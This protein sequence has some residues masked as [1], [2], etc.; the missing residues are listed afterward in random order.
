MAPAAAA[1]LDVSAAAELQIQL[2]TLQERLDKVE[3]ARVKECH[4]AAVEHGDQL[5][6]LHHKL[7]AAEMQAR[8]PCL[9]ALTPPKNTN[10][11]SGA[12]AAEARR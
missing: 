8:A 3:L 6:R 1:A 12:A 2:Q 11:A 10:Y 4:A 5:H 7:A 9:I